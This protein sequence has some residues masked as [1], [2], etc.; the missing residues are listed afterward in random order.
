MTD[1]LFAC[2][3]SN[4]AGLDNYMKTDLLSYDFFEMQR[5]QKVIIF[6]FS[7]TKIFKLTNYGL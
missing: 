4:H 2:L 7:L 1:F 3:P 6:S 5:C